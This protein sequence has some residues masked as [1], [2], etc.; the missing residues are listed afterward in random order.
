VGRRHALPKTFCPPPVNDGFQ[1]PFA[2][3]ELKPFAH[4]KE[5][6]IKMT[7]LL[8][9]T[10]I[11]ATIAWRADATVLFPSG[12][13][14]QI[15]IGDTPHAGT[16]AETFTV[17]QGTSASGS[18]SAANSSGAASADLTTGLLHLSTTGTS[19]PSMTVDPFEFL[20]FSGSGTVSYSM[21]LDGT[22]LNS[23][24][25]GD[26]SI[27]GG[28]YFYDETGFTSP[29]FSTQSSG[30][31]NVTNGYLP[32]ASAGITDV[33][34]GSSYPTTD[35]PINFGNFLVNEVQ[36]NSGTAV[37]FSPDITGSV[38][39]QAGHLY[40]I[41]LLLTAGDDQLSGSSLQTVNFA[42]TAAFDFTNLDGLTVTSS[43]GQFLS[44][45]APEPGTLL[46]LGSGLFVT[47]FAAKRRL[48]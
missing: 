6:L 43:S 25:N 7:R 29:Y 42:N 48:L 37:S 36:N 40:I 22:L 19:T 14:A 34:Y 23:S 13:T 4:S 33:L 21:Q 12:A 38:N 18:F 39:V 15:M 9:T 10:A 28:V 16:T 31:E 46:L 11:F 45:V 8:L 20:V 27:S 1:P 41:Q 35:L 26:A 44:N 47:I 30:S 24:A 2:Q 32:T 3:C 17:T 5:T